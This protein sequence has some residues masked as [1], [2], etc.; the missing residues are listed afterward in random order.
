MSGVLRAC[1]RR[2]KSMRCLFE[3]LEVDEPA[4]A[5]GPRAAGERHREHDAERGNLP[6]VL[7]AGALELDDE[8]LQEVLGR[9]V[10]AVVVLDAAEDRE[11][12]ARPHVDLEPPDP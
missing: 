4:L 12:A 7:G 8:R 9:I 2:V 11:L 6:A 3:R 1:Y 5:V 10:I